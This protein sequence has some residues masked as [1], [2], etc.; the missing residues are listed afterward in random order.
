LAGCQ[1]L[2]PHA[3]SAGR[4]RYNGIIQSTSME[5]TMSNIVRVYNRQPT[6]FMDV[7]EVDASQSFQGSLSG[8]AT[9]IGAEMGTRVSNS[10]AATYTGRLGNG[11]ADHPLP[12]AARPGV[13]RAAGHADQRQFPGTAV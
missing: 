9:S 8:G 2:G 3:I 1:L 5:Q 11:I 4:D 6:L 7:T 12:T 13:G 10:S